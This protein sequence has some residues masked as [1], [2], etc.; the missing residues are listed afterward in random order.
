MP[1]AETPIDPPAP[2]VPEPIPGSPPVP[3]PL[4]T[5]GEPGP[6]PPTEPEPVVR[7]ARH[8][9][10]RRTAPTFAQRLLVLE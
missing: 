1:S 8:G 3:S 7:A 6:V 10:R 5:P 2:P 4:P 9:R